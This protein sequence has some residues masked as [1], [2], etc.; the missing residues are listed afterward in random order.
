MG[1][2]RITGRDVEE[3]L[4]QESYETAWYVVQFRRSYMG[5]VSARKILEHTNAMRNHDLNL[6]REI[7]QYH[8]KKSMSTYKHFDLCLFNRMAHEVGG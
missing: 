6:T 3:I 2:A 8:L 7:Q 1:Q 4:K 5:I